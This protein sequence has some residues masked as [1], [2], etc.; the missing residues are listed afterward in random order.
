[1]SDI[2][3]LFCISPNFSPL[4]FDHYS[5][6]LECQAGELRAELLYCS[7]T[8]HHFCHSGSWHLH[9]GTRWACWH[10]QCSLIP[11]TEIGCSL[12]NHLV[13]RI[14]IVLYLCPG[15]TE[16]LSNAFEGPWPSVGAVGLAFYNG[17]WAYD[18]W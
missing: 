16:T 17:L 14:Y 3:M 1:M 13:I 8:F 10:Y 12:M 9:V 6:L 5:Q 18:G 7:Q 4:S 15:K 11:Y 2:L